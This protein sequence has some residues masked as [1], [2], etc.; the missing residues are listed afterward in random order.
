MTIPAFFDIFQ[1]PEMI[2]AMRV[3]Y[4][5]HVWAEKSLGSFS[6]RFMENENYTRL[7]LY[8]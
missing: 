7:L 2:I 5:I 6:I 1:P 3:L 8:F 4:Q